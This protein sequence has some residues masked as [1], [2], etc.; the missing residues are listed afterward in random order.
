MD[1]LRPE[2]VFRYFKEI[3]D[4]PRGSGNT[5]AITESLIQFAGF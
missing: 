3:S 4:I 1:N 5:D 2:N